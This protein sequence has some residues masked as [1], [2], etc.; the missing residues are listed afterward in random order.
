M[1]TGPPECESRALQR[2][3]LARLKWNCSYGIHV[4]KTSYKK[5]LGRLRVS[6]RSK[7]P[8]LWRR[9]NWLLV[10]D[11]APEHRSV[12]VQEGLARQQVTVLPHPL[13]VPDL[14]PCHFVSF[15][16]RKHSYVGVDHSAEKV[17][18]AIREA[19]RDLSANMFQR[20]F[21]Q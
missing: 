11:N 12:L 21:Q 9:K 4:N 20:C 18:T 2:S 8:E 6:A 13:Y 5:I 19:V 1:N 15:P 16:A 10:H 7:R 3:H 14:A 17:T